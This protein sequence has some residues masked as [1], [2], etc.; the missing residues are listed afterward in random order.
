MSRWERLRELMGAVMARLGRHD[1]ILLAAGLTFYAAI[2]VVPLLLVSLW[3]LSLVIGENTVRDLTL[4]LA[5]FAPEGLGFADQVADLAEVGPRLGLVS[6]LAALIPATSYGEGLVRAFDR[7]AEADTARKGLRGRL[8]SLALLAA[9]PVVVVIGLGAVAVLPDMLGFGGGA[10]A[11]GVYLTFWIGWI[12]SSLLLAVTY[13]AFTPRPVSLRA[14]LWGSVST[15]SFLT[16][17][18]L[19]WLLV[20]QFGVDVGRAYG[21]ST[22]LG[23]LV[24]FAVYLFLVQTACLIGY[25]VTLELAER[26][27]RLRPPPHLHEAAAP[28]PGAL[29]GR[30][31]GSSPASQA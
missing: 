16:G 9:L 22:M 26:E 12:A 8:L 4:R 27:G 28:D 6:F 10:I 23:T 13:R 5:D 29:S 30:P 17:M 2:A 21:G 18:S 20:L 7:L 19:G 3:A 31:G 11:L 24:L 1:L 14:L 25:T 15:G